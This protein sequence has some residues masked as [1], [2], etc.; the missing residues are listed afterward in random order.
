ML[1]SCQGFWRIVM[2][3]LPLKHFKLKFFARYF[4]DGFKGGESI[5]ERVPTLVFFS[6]FFLNVFLYNGRGHNLFF[7]FLFFSS[8]CPFFQCCT[9][10]ILSRRRV[11]NC[12][13]ARVTTYNPWLPNSWLKDNLWS[14]FLIFSQLDRI[15]P[16]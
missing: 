7:S 1:Q 4:K 12:T 6:P 3:E 5:W 16:F 15:S 9:T 14:Q 2:V 11:T 10:S 8:L 13:L